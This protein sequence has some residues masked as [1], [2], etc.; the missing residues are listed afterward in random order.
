MPQGGFGNLI[1]LPLQ[2]HAR[3]QGNTLFLDD[4]FTPH[5]DQWAFLAQTRRLSTQEVE[6]VV[7]QARG[8]GGVLGVRYPVDEEDDQRVLPKSV[9]PPLRLEGD[10]PASITAHLSDRL[11]VES[12]MLSA[13]LLNRIIRL[14]AFQNPSF[15]T[16]QAMRMNTFGIP[17]II[18]CAELVSGR[19]VLPRGCLEELESLLQTSGIGL[20]LHDSRCSGERLDVAFVGTLRPEQR[21]AAQAMLATDTGVLAATTAFGKTV[22]AAWMIAQRGV[23]TL[24]LV[25]RRQLQ[26]QWVA[27][28]SSFLG[29]PEKNIGR[30][31]GGRKT[32]TGRID[33]ALFQSL[34][35]VE[36]EDDC[37]ARYGHVVV[38]ECHAVSAVG[39]ESVV[40]RAKARYV[41][42]LSATPF[43]KDGHHP[44][45]FMQCGPIRHRVSAKQQAARRPF[46]HL[47]KVRPTTFQPSLEASEEAVPRKRF[48]RYMD[49]LCRDAGRNAKICDEIASALQAGRSP[50]ILSERVEHLTL[51]EAGLKHRLP[52]T[53]EF[54]LLKGGFGRKKLADLKARMEAVPR[55][56]PRLILATGRYLGEGFDDARLDTL[57][58]AFPVSWKGVVAQY[59]GRLHRLDDGKHEVHIH[60]YADLNVGMLARMFDRRCRGYE[61]I[62]YR[63]LLP[64]GAM[65][66]WPPEV[67]LPVDPLWNETYAAT[68]RRLIRD[69][70]DVPLADLFVFAAK[71]LTD[72]MTGVSRA[73]SAGEAFLFRRLETLKET[74]GLFALNRPLPI[75]FGES[76]TME[77]D[78]LCGRFAL[79]I[80]VDGAQHLSDATAY[81]RDRMKDILLQEQGYIVLRFLAED[82]V[83]RLDRVLDTVLRVIARRKNASATLPM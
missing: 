36:G 9:R 65:A 60:D 67:E 70:V 4:T 61:A 57:F 78:L 29:I 62:G 11:Y 2:K 59:A 50:I 68:V 64:A 46:V 69:G 71:T 51:L 25:H 52:N 31:G 74:E 1:A 42:G 3:T 66:G 44:I 76:D 38:D 37:V 83:Q 15:Y 53:T 75:P 28:L 58:L 55:N 39:F 48:R 80:E 34:L 23:S 73:R 16:A 32:L 40:R 35:R 7:S 41:L 33:V 56:K 14:A 12:N 19:V 21:A 72:G 20:I 81:R 63:I 24:V 18:S 22:L 45:I 49:E 10:R 27:R 47:V 79:A 26:E 8:R 17:R 13:P 6:T 43:R 5:D 54:F 82:V 77:V 30:W